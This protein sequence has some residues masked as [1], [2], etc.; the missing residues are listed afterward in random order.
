MK[1][2]FIAAFVAA[3]VAMAPLA[4]QKDGTG[5][6]AIQSDLQENYYTIKEGDTLQ[7][8]AAAH[9]MSVDDLRNLQP[10]KDVIREDGQLYKGSLMKVG[11]RLVSAAPSDSPT[12]SFCCAPPG[13]C[14]MCPTGS[15]GT[16]A[17]PILFP[18]PWFPFPPL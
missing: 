4:P 18:F 13:W 1:V 15:D 10:H 3:A 16:A 12:F 8:I 7:S 17:V 5:I 9:S 11:Q 2:L 6:M 14:G